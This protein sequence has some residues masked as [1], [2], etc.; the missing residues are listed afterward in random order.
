MRHLCQSSAALLK[1]GWTTLRVA[2]DADVYFAAL[3][4]RRA[5]DEGIHMGPRMTGAGHYLS[6]TGGGGDINTIAPEHAGCVVADGKVVDGPDEMR[7]AVREEIKYGSDWIKL[8]VTG[9]YM[10]MST[11]SADAPMHVHFSPQ[12]LHV[13]VEETRRLGKHVMAHAHS[14]EGIKQAVRAGVRSIEHGSFIDDE[15]IELMLQ[16]GTWLVPTQFI[17]VYY[18]TMASSASAAPLSKMLQ[19]QKETDEQSIACLRKAVAAGVKIAC[20]SDFV[21]WD[22]ALNVRE[23]ECLVAQL[24]MTPVEAL[25]AATSSAAELL[26]W[27]KRVG[28][29]ACGLLADLIVVDGDPGLDIACMRQVR[30]VVLGGAVVHST[31]P[32]MQPTTKKM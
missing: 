31:L 20:G 1:C 12:E 26:G 5:I 32:A 28:S 3:D 9:A 22:P 11:S 15:G 13:A 14:A 18:S 6:I 8:L 17:G 29:V 27:D 23:L 10:S 24:G 21:G 2:G 25:R 19:L 30:A 4:L 7:K 16:H